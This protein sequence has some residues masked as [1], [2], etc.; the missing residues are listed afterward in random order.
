MSYGLPRAFAQA[1]S[2]GDILTVRGLIVVDE[3]GVE[4]VR[5]GSPLPG[6]MINGK[7]EPR[8]GANVVYRQ[9]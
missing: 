5:I 7:R 4:R 8:Q 6:P 2:A 1:R 9:S 3:K